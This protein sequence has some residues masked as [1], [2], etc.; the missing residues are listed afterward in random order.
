MECWEQRRAKASSRSIARQRWCL[1]L[2]RAIGLL[3]ELATQF[4]RKLPGVHSCRLCERATELRIDFQLRLKLLKALFHLLVEPRPRV[5]NVWY[6]WPFYG[7]PSFSSPARF[8]G[9]AS[10][11]LST[12][13]VGLHIVAAPLYTGPTCYALVG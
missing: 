8:A 11:T 9:S 12:L 13:H 4:R 7:L 6:G 3:L 5:L 1:S 2:D 10:R